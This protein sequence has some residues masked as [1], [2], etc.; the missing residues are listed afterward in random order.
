MA[1]RDRGQNNCPH[2]NE[3]LETIIHHDE[4]GQEVISDGHVSV[5]DRRF[6]SNPDCNKQLGDINLRWEAIPIGQPS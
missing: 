6:C 4:G 2:K 3:K 5:F 1:E